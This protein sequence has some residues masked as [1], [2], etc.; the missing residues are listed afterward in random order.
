MPAVNRRA[1]RL[2]S[3]GG[4]L[5]LVVLLC[6][7][8]AA[9]AASPGQE[10]APREAGL[11]Q[12][13]ILISIGFQKG[14][15]DRL[16]TAFSR[17]V[18]TYVACAPLAADDGYYGADQMRLLLRRM[19]RGK[20]TVDFLI[21]EPAARPRPDGLAVISALWTY[22]DPTAHSARVRL[23]FALA[24]EDGSWRVREIRELK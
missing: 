15:V 18:K 7:A 12:M 19:F 10:E 9:R 14:D 21:L 6:G 20:E 13:E 11:Q 2:R 17:R 5:C 4:F 24:P 22:R 3:T 23:S 16:A 8:P 1:R